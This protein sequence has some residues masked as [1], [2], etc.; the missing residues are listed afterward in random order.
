MTRF[1]YYTSALLALSGT[2][3]AVGGIVG[4]EYKPV[5]S[6]LVLILGAA[7]FALLFV[8][9]RRKPPQPVSHSVSP[10]I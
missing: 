2:A 3:I 6:G 9:I 10:P 1:T 8:G 5:A 7:V 4:G